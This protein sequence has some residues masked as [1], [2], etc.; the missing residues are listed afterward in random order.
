[1]SAWA[2]RNRVAGDIQIKALAEAVDAR[3]SPANEFGIEVGKIEIDIGM[4]RPGHLPGD[5]LGDV[6]ARGELGQGVVVGHEPVAVSVPQVGAFAPE[7]F[8]QEMPRGAGHV[9]DRGVELHE[10]HVAQLDARPVGHRVSVG[11]GDGRVGRFAVKLP[12]P[13]G[14]QH[15]G[16]RPYEG[17]ASMPVPDQD[18]ATATLERQ[19]IDARAI[20]P[21]AYRPVRTRLR[22]H[23]PHDLAPGFITKRVHDAG[24]RVASFTTQGHAAIL[25][26]VIEMGAPADQLVD[27]LRGFPHHQIHD[28]G[29]AQTLAGGQ[30]I[31]DVVIKPVLR[32]KHPGDSALRVVAVAFAYLVLGDHEN[33]MRGLQP[34]RC[35]QAGDPTSD[36]QNVG[37]V[38]RKLL[39]VETHQVAARKREW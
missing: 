5:G 25:Q 2:D 15:H 31:G 3:E 6:V 18:T 21:D 24:V 36:H 38:M 39:G 13:A 37:E 9:Q 32:V 19:Q 11:R 26:I 29:A 1:M 23:R 16:P 7:R 35:A 27:P 30:R 28:L 17:K 33:A 8:R 4:V 22:D 12:C 20:L 10:L 14:R 34:E